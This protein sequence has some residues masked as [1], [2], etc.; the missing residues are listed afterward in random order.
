[1]DF[2]GVDLGATEIKAGIVSE[3][4][5]IIDKTAV[6]TPV[7]DGI[8]AIVN[9]IDMLIDALLKT[10]NKTIQSIKCIGVGIPG[11]C[12]NKGLVYYAPNLFWNNVPLGDLLRVKTGVPVFI[13]NDATVAIIGEATCGIARG[14]SDYVLITLG[15]GIGSGIVINNSVYN[16]SHGIGSEIGHMIVGENFYNC[17]CGNNGCLETFASA[18][19][20]VK[21]TKKLLM[22][23]DDSLISKMVD[24]VDTLDAKL[25]FDCAKKD[26]LIAGKAVDRLVKYLA[27]GIGNII[28]ILDPEMIIIGGGI[29]K[30]GNYLIEKLNREIPKNIW[31]K[32]MNLTKIVQASLGNDAGIIGSASYAK[33]KLNL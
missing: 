20:L 5:Q 26:D 13:E 19:A 1:M 25:V 8:H 18:T 21:Y 12:D 14:A 9:S 6:H 23:S 22:D 7:K 31:L 11:V 10:H 15:T 29:S 32:P 28:N 17:N 30:A 4:G 3:D 33:S 24:N 16:G 27:I 2:I